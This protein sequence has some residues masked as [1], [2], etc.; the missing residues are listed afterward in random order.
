MKKR[1]IG[2]IRRHIL[3]KRLYVYKT[4]KLKKEIIFKQAI[5]DMKKRRV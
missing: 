1:S 3:F 2:K 4:K 5:K